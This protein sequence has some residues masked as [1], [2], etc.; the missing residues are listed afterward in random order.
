LW[1][2]GTF[3]VK[4]VTPGAEELGDFAGGTSGA[5]AEQPEPHSTQGEQR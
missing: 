1:E 5:S 2:P 4:V 3:S